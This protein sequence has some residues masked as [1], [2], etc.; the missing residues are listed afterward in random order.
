VSQLFSGK[1]T[2]NYEEVK[3]EKFIE[4]VRTP[5]Y[6]VQTPSPSQNNWRLYQS[7]LHGW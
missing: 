7:G 3:F 4:V 6:E 2:L 1:D 5:S